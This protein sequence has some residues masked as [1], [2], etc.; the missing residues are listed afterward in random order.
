MLDKS[1]G[2]SV[3]CVAYDLEDSV[4]HSKK[5]EAR[6]MIRQLLQNPRS[7]DIRENAVRINA[8]QTGLALDDLTEV[9]LTSTPL[10]FPRLIHP[11]I[12]NTC[13]RLFAM[14]SLKGKQED[15]KKVGSL[16]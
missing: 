6:S 11:P 1:R 16:L 5:P 14:L 2:L 15:P 13:L 8:V 10:S 3:D 7:T 4:T 12:Y 9:H